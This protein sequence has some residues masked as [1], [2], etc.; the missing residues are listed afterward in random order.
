MGIE[1]DYLTPKLSIPSLPPSFL[2]SKSVVFGK[3]HNKSIKHTL[4]AL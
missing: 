1:K 3:Q 4:E 2:I